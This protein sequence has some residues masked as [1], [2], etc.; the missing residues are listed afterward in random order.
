[1]ESSEVPGCLIR[2]NARFPTSPKIAWSSGKERRCV[3]WSVELQINCFDRLLGGSGAENKNAEFLTAV[4][5]Q[6][7]GDLFPALARIRKVK[8]RSFCF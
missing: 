3:L 4:K 8:L 5:D 2:L 7:K 1:M 6:C